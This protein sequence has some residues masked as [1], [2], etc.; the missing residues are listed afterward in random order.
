M[1]CD[2]SLLLGTCMLLAACDPITLGLVTAGGGVAVNRQYSSTI[3]RTFSQGAE[4]V[5]A[6]VLAALERMSIQ[7]THR[8]RRGEVETFK[9]VA[10][11]RA[12]TLQ[13]EPVTRTTTLIE[14]AVRQDLLTL[15]GATGREIVAQTELALN[16]QAGSASALRLANAPA[17]NTSAAASDGAPGKTTYYGYDH[18]ASTTVAKAAKPR[19]RTTPAGSAAGSSASAPP[20]SSTGGTA[21]PATGAANGKDAGDSRLSAQSR[22]SPGDHLAAAAGT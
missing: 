13:V 11:E 21:A 12:V 2:P 20:G 16:Q 9:G 15:D 17:A 1:K 10:G 5:K 19:A 18:P 22:R 8:E 14:V 3:T 6:A 4:P 7:V